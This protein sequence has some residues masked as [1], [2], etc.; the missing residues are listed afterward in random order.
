[1]G[2]YFRKMEQCKPGLVEAES[3]GCIWNKRSSVWLEYRGVKVNRLGPLC[4]VG[5]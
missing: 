3:I 1:M 4:C 5:S 2:L